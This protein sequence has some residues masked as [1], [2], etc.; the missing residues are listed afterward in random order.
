MDYGKLRNEFIVIKRNTIV[1][2]LL[3]ILKVTKRPKE[4]LFCLFELAMFLSLEESNVG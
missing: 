1:T 4:V 2:G 3:K